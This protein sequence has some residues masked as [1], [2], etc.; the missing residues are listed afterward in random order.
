MSEY[1]FSELFQGV[2]QSNLLGTPP[3]K[4]TGITFDSRRCEPGSVF[5]ALHGW[6]DDGACYAAD[7]VKRGATL[8]VSQDALP[9]LEGSCNLLVPNV[10]DALGIVASHFYGDPSQKLE[11]VGVTGTNG[12]TTVVTLLHELMGYLG[13]KSGLLSTIENRVLDKVYP[14][15]MTTPDPITVN[16]LLKEMVDAGCRY[17][18]MEVSSHAAAQHRVAGLKFAGGV[19]TNITRDHLDYHKTFAEYL[20]AKQSFFTSLPP[21]AFA[22]VNLD[23]SHAAQMTQNAKC[24]VHT[25]SLQ[26][27]ADYHAKVRDVSF[28][29][30][31]LEVDGREVTV[32]LLGRFNAYNLLAVY[33]VGQ[34]LGFSTEQLLQG[35]S[36][37]HPVRGRFDCQLGP[38]GL[39]A[40]VDYAHTPDALE[41]IYETIEEIKPLRGNIITVMGCGGNRDQEK[42]GDMGNIAAHHSRW[43][44]ITNDNP[45]DEEPAEIANM[46]LKGI[47]KD[48]LPQVFVELDRHTAIRQ[49]CLLADSG[50]YV[51]V[52]GKGHETYQEVHGQRA[53][54]DDREEVYKAIEELK[55]QEAAL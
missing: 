8:V 55:A 28:G 21:E 3:E 11:L 35:I 10:A 2:A 48:C 43:L 54:F 31:D 4:V 27:M 1:L 34:L 17:A 42:R 25:Y 32:A 30:M 9:D 24:H 44:F 7:A 50:D 5:F 20:A 46:V 15:K 53:H 12:K 51:L 14:T 52:A 6:R 37:L 47:S 36:Q 49:A 16:A 23:D 18:F 38:N 19:F 45:R 39:V 13:C 26:E 22:L 40:I 29:A 33:G 41:K